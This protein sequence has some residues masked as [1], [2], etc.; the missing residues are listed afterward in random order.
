MPSKNIGFRKKGEEKKRVRCHSDCAALTIFDG[1]LLLEACL[2]GW[3]FCLNEII[4]MDRVYLKI[5]FYFRD[6]NF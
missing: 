5:Q 3:I 1:I 4:D 6:N 2:S